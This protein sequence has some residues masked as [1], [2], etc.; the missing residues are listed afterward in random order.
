MRQLTDIDVC[1]EA[2]QLHPER[3]ILWP[4]QH[5]LLIADI[6]LGKE[7]TFG[8]HGVPIP[9]GPSQASL[10][11]LASLIADTQPERLVVLGDLMHAEPT[12]HESW[13]DALRD[14]L[15]AHNTLDVV[16]CAGNHDRPAGQ[17]RVDSRIRWHA[18]PLVQAPFILQHHPGDDERGY[19]LAGHVHPVLWIGQQRQKKL[20][21]PVFWLRQGHA[22]LPAFGSFTGGHSIA[23]AHGERVWVCGPER[24]VAVPSPI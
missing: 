18:E 24:V 16:V 19:V 6:H 5:T 15:D 1:G 23:P 10:D 9:E 14:F 20:R 2:L 3:A 13:L 8:R 11:R 12:R 21:V 22:V 7:H 17:D 4:R